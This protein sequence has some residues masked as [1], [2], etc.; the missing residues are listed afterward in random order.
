M[1]QYATRPFCPLGELDLDL[2]GDSEATLL[3]SFRG[4]AS[5]DLEES[6]LWV[7]DLDP[8]LVGWRR[9]SELAPS[10]ALNPSLMAGLLSLGLGLCIGL[11]LRFLPRSR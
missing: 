5:E 3:L 6:R 11:L 2:L 4:A 1:Y 9:S 7:L 10:R 8:L